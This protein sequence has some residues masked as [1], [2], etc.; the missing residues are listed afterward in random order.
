MS[1]FDF[2]LLKFDSFMA[3]YVIHCLS[4]GFYFLFLISFM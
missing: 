1:F 4:Q 2:S 3:L